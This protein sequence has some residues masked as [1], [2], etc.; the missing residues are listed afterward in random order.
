MKTKLIEGIEAEITQANVRHDAS[1][2]YLHVI[3]EYNGV[4]YQR[5][6]EPD[7]NDDRILEDWYRDNAT[8]RVI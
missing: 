7:A 8:W 6:F 3:V 5:N 4:E 2:D 1:R